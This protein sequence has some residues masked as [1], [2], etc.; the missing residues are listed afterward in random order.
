[1]SDNTYR[2]HFGAHRTQTSSDNVRSATIFPN[3]NE[4][5][6]TPIVTEEKPVTIS[7][8]KKDL[9]SSKKKQ[10]SKFA[11]LFDKIIQRIQIQY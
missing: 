2:K 9:S 5:K 8:E 4:S 10:P 3:S 6:N 1:M 11:N 7:E